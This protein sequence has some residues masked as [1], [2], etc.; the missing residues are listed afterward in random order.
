MTTGHTVETGYIK[1][2]LYTVDLVLPT[3]CSEQIHVFQ[4]VVVFMKHKHT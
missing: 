1:N 3:V 4:L 2:T